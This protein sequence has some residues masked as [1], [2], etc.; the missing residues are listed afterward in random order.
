MIFIKTARTSPELTGL[1]SWPTPALLSVRFQ[2]IFHPQALLASHGWWSAVEWPGVSNANGII[3]LSQLETSPDTDIGL[4]QRWGRE[5]Y[6]KGTLW[7]YII[8]NW[9]GQFTCQP[10]CHQSQYLLNHNFLFLSKIQKCKSKLSPLK[11]WWLL[12]L[13]W[14]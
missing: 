1:D 13:V 9:E 12:K 5:G 4:T 2:Q 11:V 14:F 3:W 10:L 7:F 6:Y 8:E